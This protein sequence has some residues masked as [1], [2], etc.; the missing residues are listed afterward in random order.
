MIRRCRSESSTGYPRYGAKGITVCEHWLSFESFLKDVGPRPNGTTLDRIDGSRGY[1]PG[2]VR[3][4]TAIEQQRNTKSNKL[5]TFR[6]RTQCIAAWADET[7]IDKNLIAW[8][9]RNGWAVEIALTTPP[10]LG[11]RIR[12]TGQVLL[13]MNGRSQS[14]SAWSKETGLS[15]S[16]IRLRISKGMSVDE[17]LNRP[18]G[19]WTKANQGNP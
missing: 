7:G 15:H 9:L 12:T 17:A 2:N 19:V 4:A 1:E 16:L 8:R 5:V 13:T 6:G 3:W 18:K 11:N 10:V 14:I